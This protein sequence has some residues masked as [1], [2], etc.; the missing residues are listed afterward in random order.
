[1]VHYF[2]MHMMNMSNKFKNLMTAD[3]SL[4]LKNKINGLLGIEEERRFKSKKNQGKN[5]NTSSSS[6]FVSTSTNAKT[7]VV[8][9]GK[10]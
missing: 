2:T 8:N 4:L 10:F 9:R 3:A 7:Y 5:K 6:T 1:M